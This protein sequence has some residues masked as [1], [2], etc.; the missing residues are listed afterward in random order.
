MQVSVESTGVLDRRMTVRIPNDRVTSEI[1][2]R[3]NKLSR[4][5]RIAGFRPGKVPLRVVKQRYGAGV[6][7]QVL[8][9]MIENTYREAV[10]Q[11][12]LQ[13]VGGPKIDMDPVQSGGAE[14]EF[15]EFVAS[16]QVFPEIQVGDFS[17]IA[18]ERP[19]VEI[20][21]ADVERVL[22]SLR[23][24]RK[25]WK[26]V[27]REVQ[28]GDRAT[29]TF[30]GRIDGELF[31]GGSAEEMPVEVGSRQFLPDFESQ[32]PGIQPGGQKTIDV[33]FP[34]DYPAEHLQG[35]VAQFDL[36]VIRVEEPVLPEIDEDFAREFGIPDG[37]IESLRTEVRTNM[38]RELE[39]SIRSR[40]KQ[41]VMDALNVMHPV[42]LP[43]AAVAMEVDRLREDMQKRLEQSGNKT[44]PPLPDDAFRG[45]AERRVRMGL[46]LRS[47]IEK[48]TMQV[49]FDRLEAELDSMAQTYEHPDE[50]KQYY[51]GN[52]QFMGMLESMV[53]E[54]QVVD[55]ILEK[56]QV[57]EVH[58]GFDDVM[59]SGRPATA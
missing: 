39:N 14:K 10:A 6:S 45:E 44:L 18:I 35:R 7:Q 13:P 32:L 59:N 11:E 20:T 15:F 50:V 51:R 37:N 34:Q 47:I 19:V 49:D 48:H 26:E 8:S 52:P 27:S 5:V 33:S 46:I 55:L 42:D 29:L 57:T 17:E 43:E 38:S 12:G 23:A 30:Q 2:K 24:Q 31:E 21:S 53:L 54:N 36:T 22:G 41:Q 1:D 58:R 4:E 56:A 9:E 40:L 3:L 25:T 16:F 28:D